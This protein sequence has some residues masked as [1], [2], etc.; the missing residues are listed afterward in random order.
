M[1]KGKYLRILI[2]ALVVALMAG[3]VV[4]LSVNSSNKNKTEKETQTT[5]TRFESVDEK[6]DN[7][8]DDI[9]YD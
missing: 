6:F 9:F 3:A 5:P 1:D 8:A 2:Y 7:Y 4:W